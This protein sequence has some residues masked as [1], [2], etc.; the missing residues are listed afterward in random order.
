VF[1]LVPQITVRKRLDIESTAQKWIRV[2]PQLVLQ[3][4][5]R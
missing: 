2:L 1:I 5:P 4:W 3:Q